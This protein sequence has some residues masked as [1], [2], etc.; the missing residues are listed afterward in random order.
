MQV[1]YQDGSKLTR[2]AP[3]ACAAL[4]RSDSSDPLYSALRTQHASDIALE[5]QSSSHD[6]PA[7]QLSPTGQPH[8]LLDDPEFKDWLGT[9]FLHGRCEAGNG[10]GSCTWPKLARNAACGPTVGS[11]TSQFYRS[12]VYTTAEQ[13]DDSVSYEQGVHPMQGWP[14]MGCLS[15]GGLSRGCLAWGCLSRCRL[16]KTLH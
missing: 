11:Y 13:V 12:C 6:L 5:A 16:S 10:S 1:S 4:G 7:V 2:A 14:G 8:V 15:R 3:A 9:E